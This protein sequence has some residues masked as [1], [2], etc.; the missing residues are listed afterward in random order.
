VRLL[1]SVFES[2]IWNW[3]CVPKHFVFYAHICIQILL[4]PVLLIEKFYIQLYIELCYYLSLVEA[5]I[6]VGKSE[7]DREV[8]EK[9]RSYF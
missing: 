4:D 5:R 9:V 1:T 2:P 8:V 6:D 7:I 3:A